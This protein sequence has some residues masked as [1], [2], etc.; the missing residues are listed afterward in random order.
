MTSRNLPPKG[1]ADHAR[2]ETVAEKEAFSSGGRRHRI[3]LRGK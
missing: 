1:S 2:P 3:L